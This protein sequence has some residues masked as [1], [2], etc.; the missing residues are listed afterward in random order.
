MFIEILS[1]RSGGRRW[2]LCFS[3]PPRALFKLGFQRILDFT[4]KNG[5]EMGRK[6][7][8]GMDTLRGS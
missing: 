7:S 1:W 8:L 6:G 4:A 3:T 5:P 2:L